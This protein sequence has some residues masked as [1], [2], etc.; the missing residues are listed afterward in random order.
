MD[1]ATVRP[2]GPRLN[3]GLLP[4]DGLL[5]GD[6]ALYINGTIAID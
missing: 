6:N 1:G 2:P 3:L 5:V 4:L